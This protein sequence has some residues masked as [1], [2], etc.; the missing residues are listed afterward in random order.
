MT[1]AFFYDTVQ[2]V[3][4]FL[5]FIKEDVMF[6]RNLQNI[7]NTRSEEMHRR[8][9]MLQERGHCFFCSEGQELFKKVHLFDSEDWYVAHN[10]APLPGSVTHV[11]AVPR[12]H[13]LIPSDLTALERNELFDSIIPWVMEKLDMPGASIFFRIGDTTITGSTLC[14]LHVHLVRGVQRRDSDHKPIFAVVGF[15]ADDNPKQETI[16]GDKNEYD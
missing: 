14:H 15:R 13:V 12:R 2:L 6:N 5:I 11:I 3:L 16:T 7:A 9:L 1:V 8:M 4:V 10:D